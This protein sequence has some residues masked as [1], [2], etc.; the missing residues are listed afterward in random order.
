M[1]KNQAQERIAGA[2]INLI[3]ANSLLSAMEDMLHSG[4]C[5]DRMDQL[6][7]LVVSARDQVITVQTKLDCL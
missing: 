6:V 5:D 1:A 4:S 3:Y 7:A 2:E